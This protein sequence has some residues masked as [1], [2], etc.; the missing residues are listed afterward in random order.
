MF[1]LTIVFGSVVLATKEAIVVQPLPFMRDSLF[2]LFTVI[3]ITIKGLSGSAH[4]LGSSFGLILIY[5][6]YV[7][8]V[9]FVHLR[10]MNMEIFSDST[11]EN[12]RINEFLSSW[13]LDEASE[14]LNNEMQR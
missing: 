7:L 3:I 8:V 11:E 13:D 4:T 9:M 5:V 10:A 12:T 2:F 6:L 1:L 14:D